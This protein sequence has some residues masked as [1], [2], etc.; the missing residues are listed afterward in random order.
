MP[1]IAESNPEPE[2]RIM[3]VFQDQDNREFIVVPPGD[4][5]FRVARLTCGTSNGAKTRGCDQYDLELLLEGTG[6]VVFDTLID[7]RDTSWKLD[8]FLR[9]CGV[10]LPRGAAWDFN[11][12][13]C[14]QKGWHWVDPDGLRGWAKITQEPVMQK[15]PR[16]GLYTMP[17][18]G[19]DGQALMRNRV[20]R[21]YTDR[22]KLPRHVEPASAQEPVSAAADD[23]DGMPF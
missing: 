11:Q 21:Y 16:T 5:V 14:Q 18:I 19:K 7:H 22:E 4:Y 20:G 1:F 15:D 12:R 13:R 8:V 10:R 17:K 2:S 23:D 3:P 6:A 9:C